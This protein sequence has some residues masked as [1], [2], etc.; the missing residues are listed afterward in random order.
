MS[1]IGCPVAHALSF[2]V[3]LCCNWSN[4]V[5]S[6]GSFFNEVLLAMKSK[7]DGDSLSDRKMYYFSG[8]DTSIVAIQALLGIPKSSIISV[9]HPGSALIFEL[10]QDTTD[11]PYYVEVIIYK[12]NIYFI[13]INLLSLIWDLMD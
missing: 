1:I 8:H 11:S 10:H 12:I 6:I 2:T 13:M 4:S 9:V 5:V 7:V 3:Q